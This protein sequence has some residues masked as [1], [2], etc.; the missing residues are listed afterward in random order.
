MARPELVRTDMDFFAHLADDIAQAR[1]KVLLQTM[2]VDFGDLDQLAEP[3]VR[4][5]AN[6]A[7][8]SLV[9]DRYSLFDAWT[10]EGRT[11]VKD[12]RQHLGVLSTYG[13]TIIPT[14]LVRMNPCAGRHHIKT[15]ITDDIVYAGGGANLTNDTKKTSDFMLRYDNAEAAE[16]LFHQ[17]PEIASRRFAGVVLPFDD[18]TSYL[19]DGGQRG[20]S[21]IYQQAIELMADADQATIVSKMVPNGPLVEIAPPDTKFYYNRPELVGK[22]NRLS[23]RWNELAC[24]VPPNSYTGDIQLHAKLCLARRSL[25]RVALTGSHNFNTLGVHFGTQESALLTTSE[26]VCDLLESYIKD[27]GPAG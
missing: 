13:I 7:E 27:C 16:R 17:L 5:Q 14:G 10:K 1:R 15:Y 26:E 20:Q 11:G 18:Q 4:A 19:V 22:F 8:V 3:M 21:P 12:L 6:G 23:L 2:S 24:C 25:G 9:Y